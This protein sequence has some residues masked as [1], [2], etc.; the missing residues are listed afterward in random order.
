MGYERRLAGEA[1][2]RDDLALM[3]ARAYNLEIS[4][5]AEVLERARQAAAEDPQARSVREWVALL[6]EHDTP[7]VGKR[8]AIE[9]SARLAQRPAPVAPMVPGRK[10]LVMQQAELDEAAAEERI[11]RDASVRL[12]APEEPLRSQRLHRAVARVE[13]G[14]DVVRDLART[15]RVARPGAGAPAAWQWF[16]RFGNGARAMASPTGAAAEVATEV[17]PRAAVLDASGGTRSPASS[18]R[19]WPLLGRELS[20]VRVHTAPRPTRRRGRSARARSRSARTSS[21]RGH[22]VPGRRR[23]RLLIP[24]SPRGP[25]RRGPHPREQ[26]RSRPSASRSHRVPRR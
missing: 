16:E 11:R 2:G 25:A 14:F 17:D 15:V 1:T 4:H 18:A 22:F 24:S 8:T 9:A 26:R 21:C 13:R 19:G 3:L 12:P 10:T 6:L 23:R 20:N 7:G 5:A